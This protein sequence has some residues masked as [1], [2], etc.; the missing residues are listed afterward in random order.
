MALKAIYEN[1]LVEETVRQTR[2]WQKDIA[3]RG[4]KISLKPPYDQNGNDLK[5]Q[6]QLTLIVSYPP[7]YPEEVPDLHLEKD[8]GL[9]DA[10]FRTLQSLV[11]EWAEQ[12]KGKPRSLALCII[13]MV[14]DYMSVNNS[15]I[16][17]TKQISA[18]EQM[19][20]RR[21]HDELV[22]QEQIRETEQ[23]KML[24][25]AEARKEEDD[26][27]LRRIVD[28]INQK[29]AQRKELLRRKD[30]VP[31]LDVTEMSL[32]T[33]QS[34]SGS[35]ST[36]TSEPDSE[37]ATEQESD[38]SPTDS[39]SQE[40]AQTR[41]MEFALRGS[42][43]KNGSSFYSIYRVASYENSSD[44]TDM[45]VLQEFRIADEYYTRAGADGER[46][47]VSIIEEIQTLKETHHP[48]IVNLYDIQMRR[49]R[50]E[51][52][53]ET[54]Q[55]YCNGGSLISLLKKCGTMSLTNARRFL[56]HA[57]K[58]LVFLHSRNLVHRDIKPQTVFFT[59]LEGHT[60]SIL[61]LGNAMYMRKLLDL[62]RARPL[63]PDLP[64][65]EVYPSGWIAPELLSR[66]GVYGSKN[67]IW[68]LGRTFAEMLLGL[69]VTKKYNSPEDLYKNLEN[70]IPASVL[71][72][73]RKTLAKDSQERSTAMELLSHSLFDDIND[74]EIPLALDILAL[75]TNKLP[76]GAAFGP[77]AGAAGVGGSILLQ[78]GQT[79][80][81]TSLM[82]VY[83]KT[84]SRYKMDFEEIDF[85]G[86]G[87]FGQVVKARNKIDGRFYAIKQI[88]LDPQD[89]ENSRKILREVQTL[90]MLHHQ[91]VVRYYQAWFEDGTGSTWHDDDSDDDF[92]D[93]SSDDS[94]LS[95]DDTSDDESDNDTSTSD[96][97]M[98]STPTM[99]NQRRKNLRNMESKSDWL[100]SHDH[101]KSSKL[102]SISFAEPDISVTESS[103]ESGGL[104]RISLYIQMEY[105]EKKTLRDVIDQGL[106]DE[107]AWRLLRQIVE[108]LAHIHSLGMIHRDL[109]PSFLDANE[110]VKIGDFG[111]ATIRSEVGAKEGAFHPGQSIESRRSEIDGTM[112][113]EIGTPIYVAPEV[114]SNSKK[115]NSK[116]DIYS[117]GIW[118]MCYPLQTGMERMVVLRDLRLPEI[119]FPGDFDCK[120]Y[121]KQMSIIQSF[122]SHSPK[123]RPSCAAIL[124]SNLLPPK[125]EEEY[126]T[127][128]LRS[129]VDQNNPLY[130]S[131]LV[132][133]LFAQTMDKHKDFTYDFNCGHATLEE[134]ASL[135]T[136]RVRSQ[137]LKIFQL[138]GAMEIM[139]PS[140]IPKSE[141]YTNLDIDKS[142]ALLDQ[143]GVLVSLPYDLIVPFARYIART[144][145]KASFKRG[146]FEKIYRP[147]LVG[148]QPRSGYSCNFDIVTLEETN[149]LP[150]AEVLKV[151]M[152]IIEV[153]SPRTSD[154]MIFLSHESI[155]QEILTCCKITED[156]AFRRSV[157]AV[158][159]ELDASLS[160]AQVRYKLVHSLNVPRATVDVLE[161][162]YMTK[163]DIE[164][165]RRKLDGLFR[166]YGRGSGLSECLSQL[167]VLSR[168]CKQFGIRNKVILSPLL[169][170]NVVYYGKGIMFHIA[171]YAKNRLDIIAAGGRYDQLIARYRGPFLSNRRVF[172]VGVNIAIQKLIQRVVL[173]HA[174][175]LRSWMSG[176]VDEMHS[177]LNYFVRKVD[178]LVASFAKG[179]AAVDDRMAIAAECWSH[180]ISC[181]VMEKD[182]TSP[183][184][185]IQ[186]ALAGGYSFCIYTK[187]KDQDSKSMQ[188]KVKNMMTRQ[189]DDVSRRDLISFLQ[190]EL[191]HYLRDTGINK[192]VRSG[193]AEGNSHVREIESSQDSKGSSS[194]TQIVSTVSFVLSPQKNRLKFKEQN[195]I[196]E[197]AESSISRI[198]QSM[199]R[200][201]IIAVDLALSVLKRIADVDI[202]DDAVWRQLENQSPGSTR[203][204]LVNTRRTMQKSHRDDTS[205]H[206]WLYSIP[207]SAPVLYEFRN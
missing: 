84:Q 64:A 185:I 12:F 203:E 188:I 102:F 104:Y 4:L 75:H 8:K 113:S 141:I 39:Q 101:S 197:R 79:Q 42:R 112:T 2:A 144:N 48:N 116:V 94:E 111:L 178:V 99:P 139:V 78:A 25:E 1:D 177:S 45:L 114:L 90:S 9:S 18:H 97:V 7:N 103:R 77:P 108:G 71:S 146:T 140:L 123:A 3:R 201:R 194:S 195:R 170:Q 183:Q 31:S 67:D 5:G 143:S 120:K 53:L 167:V 10:Q 33:Q 198:V 24:E 34:F 159:Q 147:N 27:F 158:L 153:C 32:R 70:S 121:A 6:V 37:D 161:N 49:E 16:R 199:T 28:E 52:F 50:G 149:L 91:F 62:H 165:S 206:I 43:I 128:A 109:K 66:P 130:Y 205:R 19:L 204:Q 115:Y 125:L 72:V 202:N 41:R 110:N 191:S 61:M 11:P 59:A 88:K 30:T 133:A 17:G 47:L 175:S 155:L 86:R 172:A 74:K 46:K 107:E 65:E 60:E 14:Q 122:L 83:G 179:Q 166:T 207:D 135:V 68:C 44:D 187:M 119:K 20:D 160:F 129:V 186:T 21:E 190:T 138:H 132:T 55:E 26:T 168:Y 56:R 29:K 105:C 54:L 184:E 92:S 137:V 174:D 35:E 142:V 89:R 150:E 63:R 151:V 134:L 182:A 96:G 136:A 69:G 163:G 15:I 126:V 36:T 40:P 193:T 38:R 152:D 162:F 196:I 22:K 164:E 145:I 80:S 181:E 93:E 118:S 154:Y 100:V 124:K 76:Q 98:T 13:D 51:I 180:G 176:K 169:S 117:L 58:G 81:S 192:T 131:R 200:T 189:E 157:F 127:E 73:L 85:L 148:G 57:L 156:Q 171:T 173:E 23:R 82:E 87:G 95:D 106:A